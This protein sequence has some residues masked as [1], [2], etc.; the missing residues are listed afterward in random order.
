MSWVYTVMDL[1][2]CSYLE[3]PNFGLVVKLFFRDLC[4]SFKTISND[5]MD[6]GQQGGGCRGVQRSLT[7]G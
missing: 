5:F 3:S 6:A 7:E 4:V 2:V 1:T